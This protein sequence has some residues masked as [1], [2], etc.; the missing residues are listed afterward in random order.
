MKKKLSVKRSFAAVLFFII[1]ALAAGLRP[2]D[3]FAGEPYQK[4]A[5]DTEWEML[6]AINEY[7]LKRDLE[8]MSMFSKLQTAA[9]V[10]VND[11]LSLSGYISHLRPNGDNCFSIL[12][13]KK[14]YYLAAAENIAAGQDDVNAVMTAWH[15]SAGHRQNM[16]NGKLVHIGC[17]YGTGGDFGTYWVQLFVGGCTVR[18]IALNEPSSEVYP[19]GTKIGDMNRYLIVK[20][21]KHGTSYTPV[22]ARMCS[23]YKASKAGWQTVTVTFHGKKAEMKVYLSED[24]TESGEEAAEDVQKPA[25]VKGF[26]VKR[27]GKTA[28]LTWKKT[29]CDGYEIYM[30]SKKKSG[31]SRVKT[32]RSRNTLTFTKKRIALT[33]KKYFRIRAYKMVNG[34][35]LRGS[36]SGV[37]VL[38]S[39]DI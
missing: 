25:A 32:I 1:F 2:A 21:N 9:N 17:G 31:Y 24:E 38:K 28:V 37:K 35:K 3:A 30:S 7:R 14:I 15:N 36:L 20:C 34:K 4:I 10:R 18:S 33:K 12:T 22:T 16:Q 27:K 13:K 39:A 19:V 26:K 23:G 8:A 6:S 5:S 29:E 11:N